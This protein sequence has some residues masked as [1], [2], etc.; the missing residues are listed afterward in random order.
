MGWGKEHREFCWGRFKI[1]AENKDAIDG[2]N[3]YASDTGTLNKY[4]DDNVQLKDVSKENYR[5]AYAR[6]AQTFRTHLEASGSCR[7]GKF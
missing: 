3:P 5:R 1:W 7:E 4:W 6:L 2:F